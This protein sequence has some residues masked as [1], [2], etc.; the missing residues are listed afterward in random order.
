MEKD[1][2]KEVKGSKITLEIGDKTLELTV[3]EAK[4][5]QDSLNNLFQDRIVYEKYPYLKIPLPSYPAHPTGPGDYPL[6][7]IW[8]QAGAGDTWTLKIS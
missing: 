7:V 5:L 2:V 4:K 6:P 8:C 3:E 1:T